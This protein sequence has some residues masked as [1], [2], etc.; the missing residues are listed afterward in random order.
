MVRFNTRRSTLITRLRERQASSCSY[1][2]FQPKLRLIVC[3][4]NLF[5][6]ICGHVE[7]TV[8]QPATLYLNYRPQG[9]IVRDMHVVLKRIRCEIANFGRMTLS[10]SALLAMFGSHFRLKKN[11]RRLSLR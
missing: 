5:F 4:L 10:N 9:K 7:I 1:Q 8:R 2:L 11:P 6:S 3:V